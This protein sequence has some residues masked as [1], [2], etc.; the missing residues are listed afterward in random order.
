VDIAENNASHY[1]LCVCVKT[2]MQDQLL[3]LHYLDGG[4]KFPTKQS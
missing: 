4:R 3:T 2:E 1:Q